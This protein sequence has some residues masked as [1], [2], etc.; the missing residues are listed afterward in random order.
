MGTSTFTATGTQQQESASR[1]RPAPRSDEEERA[2]E[3]VIKL[4]GLPASSPDRA[5]LRDRV[6][7]AWLPMANRLARRYAR[8]GEPFDDL[9]QTAF[10]GLIKS[11][12]GF[13]P[14]R[15]TDFLSYAIPT[16][17]GE[18]KRHFRDRTWCVRVPRRM[19]EMRQS[20]GQAEIELS[21]QLH[22]SPTVADI[23]AHLDVSEEQVLEGLEG[24]YAYRALSLSSPVGDAPG[25]E[26]GDTLGS[27]EH[28]YE[29]VELCAALPPAMAR[30]TNR[31]RQII[32]MRFH[33][34]LTQSSIAERIGVSQ[35]HVS[36]LLAGALRK[37][38]HHLTEIG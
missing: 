26:L 10:I 18:I 4:A 36:R 14:Q 29:L 24:G 15:G 21:Q 16:I 12:D 25:L 9:R 23:A 13:D 38:R 22:R 37:L 34:N 8:R 31:E 20:I 30:L 3:L 7:E 27:C 32:V 19:Q 33:G 35:M 2:A 17:I 6:I 5:I 1:D 11:V 28:G